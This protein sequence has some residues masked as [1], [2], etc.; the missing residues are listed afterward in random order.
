MTSFFA[1]TLP[2]PHPRKLPLQSQPL[3]PFPSFARTAAGLTAESIGILTPITV[4][5]GVSFARELITCVDPTSIRT[6]VSC[7]WT[8]YYTTRP[9]LKQAIRRTMATLRAAEG[10][11]AL[12]RP[13]ST[14]WQGA[15][16]AL[17]YAALAADTEA[18]PAKLNRA[19]AIARSSVPYAGY[20]WLSAFQRL[21]QVSC[22]QRPHL[23][24]RG[25]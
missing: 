3:R 1:K 20:S 14:G 11:M 25:S 22:C 15:A 7:R 9:Q 24:N 23:G 12:A 13:W 5:P 21:E 10:L 16:D 17:L 6:R 18:T 2:P 4:T 19:S 8:G